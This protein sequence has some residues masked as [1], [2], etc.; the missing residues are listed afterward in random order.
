MEDVVVGSP[1]V[2]R[3]FVRG[4][5]VAEDRQDRN[6]PQ[7]RLRLRAAD[8]NSTV[9][10]IDVAPQQIAQLMGAGAHEDQRGENRL[11]FGSPHQRIAVHRRRLQQ[12]LD[13][14]GG[15]EVNRALGRLL[16]PTFPADRDVLGDE[17]LFERR[18]KDGLKAVNRLVD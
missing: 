5:D 9:G 18:A 1:S 7:T 10:K 13:L 17:L 12:R 11:P 8:E 6:L 15:V 3:G 14:P 4:E 16:H 2:H